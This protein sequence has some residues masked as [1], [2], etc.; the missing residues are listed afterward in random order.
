MDLKEKDDVLIVKSLVHLLAAHFHLLSSSNVTRNANNLN[1]SAFSSTPVQPHSK[2][3]LTI[4][5]DELH[6][7]VASIK[8]TSPASTCSTVETGVSA[9]ESK[10]TDKKHRIHHPFS[11]EEYSWASRLIRILVF[12]MFLYKLHK[13][14][15][16]VCSAHFSYSAFPCLTI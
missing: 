11:N 3:T 5:R 15:W 1:H 4:S 12:L 14:D 6:S 16:T 7:Q 9:E 8:L 10:M 2:Y 13:N